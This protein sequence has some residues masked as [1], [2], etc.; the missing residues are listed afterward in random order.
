MSGI[1]LNYYQYN[2]LE[3]LGWNSFF[4]LNR[5]CHQMI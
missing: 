4:L 5:S 1:S 3:K 2:E